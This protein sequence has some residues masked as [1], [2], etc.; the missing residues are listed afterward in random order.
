MIKD[1]LLGICCRCCSYC[2]Y[3]KTDFTFEE[4]IDQI[5]RISRHLLS[6]VSEN[7]DELMEDD[8]EI[9]F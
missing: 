5:N 4:F 9:N 2:N 8:E 6:E 1:M 3:M 7:V